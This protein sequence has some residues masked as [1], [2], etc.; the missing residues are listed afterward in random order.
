MG[1]WSHTL[2]FEGERMDMGL[3]DER[4]KGVYWMLN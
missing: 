2:L 3:N 1:A 4:G